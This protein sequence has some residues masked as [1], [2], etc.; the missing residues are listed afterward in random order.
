M[1][2]LLILATAVPPHELRTEDVIREATGIFAGRHSGFRAADAGVRQ[3]RH[4]AALFGA[5]PMNG[6]AASKAGRSAPT[7]SSR[8]PRC[9][10]PRCRAWRW[11][12]AGLTAAEIDTIVMVSSTGVATPSIEARMLSELGFR[13]DV[14]RVPVFGLGCAGRRLR[15]VAG[16]A[17]RQG[18]ARFEGAAGGDRTLH[19]GLPAR[20]D[21]EVQH[22]RHRAVRRWRGGSRALDRGAR[23]MGEIEH[24]GEHTW[25]GTTDV[26]GWRMDREGFGAIFSRSIPDL[27]TTDLRPAADAFLERHGLS[28][29]DTQTA[30][31][32]T[33]AGPRSSSRWRRPSPRG[34][35]GLPASAQVLRGL[36]QHVRADRVVRSGAG[37]GTGQRRAAASSRRWARALPPASSPCCTEAAHVAQHHHSLARHAATAGRALHRPPQH[38]EAASRAAASSWARTII[39]S[40]W[41]CT[42]C[43]CWGC[44]IW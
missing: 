16:G 15:P 41:R 24:A 37:T 14:Q 6:S 7:P 2:G 30:S 20:R 1:A 19:A 3:L 33:P 26:M 12:Q 17:P 29:G 23:R 32:S 10:S 18:R 4:R 9:S 39:P 28:F 11:P 34:R 22:H 5:S 8:A 21:V 43:G 25:P 40:S 44:G 36:W 42:R 35:N 31:A 27:A 13:A 38:Q